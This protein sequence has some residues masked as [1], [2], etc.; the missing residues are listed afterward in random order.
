MDKP[1][2]INLPPLTPLKIYPSDA[3]SFS[4]EEILFLVKLLEDEIRCDRPSDENSM[5]RNLKNKFLHLS[6]KIR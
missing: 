1:K 5:L 2:R 3:V 4:T 6:V